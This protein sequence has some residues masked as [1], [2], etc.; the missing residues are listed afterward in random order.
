MAYIGRPLNAGNLSVDVFT[1]NASTTVFTLTY[2]VGSSNSIGVYLDGVRQLGGTDFTASGTA[3]TFTTA[4]A[5]SVGIDVYFLGLELSIPT[6]ADSSVTAAKLASNAVTSVKIID[7]AV[8]LA[9]MAPGTDGNIIS[10]DASGNPV[11]IATGNDGQVLTSTGAGSPPAFEALPSAGVTLGTA[12]ATTSGTSIDFTGIPSGTKRIILSVD[13]ISIASGTSGPIVQLGDSG[14]FETSGYLGSA[15]FL[16]SAGIQQASITTG[17]AMQ[18]ST[19]ATVTLC[20]AMSITLLDPN[21]FTWC[22]TFFAGRGDNTTGYAGGSSKSLSA[23]L[24]Q[25][26]LTTIDGSLAWDNGKINIQYE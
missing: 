14:G 26:R 20:G 16:G 12:V 3:L 5:N 10:Y 25:I 23:E 8:T 4:P 7:D 9:K 15:F 13:Q 22:S 19:N 11:A 17:L 21:T 2:S 24:T 6:P 1:G 18:P